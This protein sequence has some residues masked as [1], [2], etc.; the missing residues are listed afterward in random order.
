M[1]T[2]GHDHRDHDGRAATGTGRVRSARHD[3]A[4]AAATAN[5]ITDRKQPDVS[6]APLYD[7]LYETYSALYPQLQSLFDASGRYK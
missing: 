3:A 2:A 6:L 4:T 7:K 5:A 1:G